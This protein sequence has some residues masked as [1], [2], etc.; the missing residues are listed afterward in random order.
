M[1]TQHFG[2]TKTTIKAKLGADGSLRGEY[3]TAQSDKGPFEATRQAALIEADIIIDGQS[4]TDEMAKIT[5]M[6]RDALSDRLV[7]AAA[8]DST[9]LDMIRS[10]KMADNPNVRYADR[11]RKKTIR[12]INYKLLFYPPSPD[13]AVRF[14]QLLETLK[15]QVSARYVERHSTSL[16][17]GRT[18]PNGLPLN[19]L[20][21][22]VLH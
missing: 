16:H 12:R 15:E 19:R 11:E 8:E 9:M 14:C 20:R 21:V 5:G 7:A 10:Y 17:L 2:D 18:A 6:L 4:E 1:I 3:E 22:R 13:G